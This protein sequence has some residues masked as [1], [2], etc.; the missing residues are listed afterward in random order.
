MEQLGLTCDLW[1]EEFAGWM[2]SLGYLT[3]RR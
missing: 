1:F 3:P 2:G